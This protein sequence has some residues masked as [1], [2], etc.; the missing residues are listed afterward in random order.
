M[1]VSSALT[2]KLRDP[3][4]AVDKA[5]VGGEWI[6][7]SGS[8]ATFEVTNPSTG[9]VIAVPRRRGPST[10]PTPSRRNGRRG[11]ARNAR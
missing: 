3:G 8:G 1:T 4:L 6:D 7:R 10:S 2:G 5:Y 9:E 11:L